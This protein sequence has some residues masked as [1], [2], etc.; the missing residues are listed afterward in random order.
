MGDPITSHKRIAIVGGGLAGLSLAILC[1]QSGLKVHVFEKGSYP[2]HKVCGEYISMESWNFLT[3][4]LGI[5]LASHELPQIRK[6]L[7]T[8]H[9]GLEL[10]ADL[11]LGGFGVSRYLIDMLLYQKALELGVDI[12]THCSISLIE[13]E[14]GHFVLK[15]Q[16]HNIYHSDLCVSAHG[17]RSNVDHILQRSFFVNSKEKH[18]FV[19]V[20][21]HVRSDAPSDTIAL[22]NFDGGYCGFSKIEGDL[23]CLCYLTTAHNLK[24]HGSIEKMEQEVLFKNPKLKQIFDTCVFVWDKPL[25]ISQIN[26]SN[27]DLVKNH[28]LFIGDAAGV[29]QPLCGN[30]MSM[31]MHSAYILHDVITKSLHTRCLIEIENTYIQEWNRTFGTR[32]YVARALSKLFGKK[33]STQLAIALLKKTPQ[34]TR[35]VIQ[36]THGKEI[37]S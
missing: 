23:Y 18:N 36:L 28:I 1:A 7:V 34:L 24:K 33:L 5:D 29:I 19:A 22:H 9:T 14:A 26:F 4:Q 17:K 20:K 32:L 8:S 15:D 6:L 37:I 21:Y 11:P 25:T 31:A 27:K 30:G 35:K 10:H 13:R 16:D 3:L 2:S 12:Q